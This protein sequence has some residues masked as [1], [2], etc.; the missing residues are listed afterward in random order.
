VKIQE[1]VSIKKELGGKDMSFAVN[2]LMRH[3]F[4]KLGQGQMGTVLKHAN[5]PY[6]VKVFDAQ[7]SAYLD[8]VRMVQSSGQNP[9]FPLFK[10]KPVKLTRDTWAIRMETLKP[11]ERNS[12]SVLDRGLLQILYLQEDGPDW[13]QNLEDPS[14]AE[15]KRAVMMVLRKW[16][17]MKQ[18]LDMLQEFEATHDHA[19]WDL[20]EMNVMKRGNVPV[21]TDP[22]A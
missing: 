17:R 15:E 7:D 5:L 16:P 12:A 21:F 22:F 14:A 11:W 6:V 9:H 20:H 8:F 18:A 19:H 1:L 13:I 3:G 2:A 4:E 10:G